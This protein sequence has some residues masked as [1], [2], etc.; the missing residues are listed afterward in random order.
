MRNY[1][2]ISYC[3]MNSHFQNGIAKRAIR[4]LQDQAQKQLVH[5]KSQWPKAIHLVFWPYALQN[6]VHLRNTLPTQ[7]ENRSRLENFSSINVGARLVNNQTF[8][9]PVYAMQ[10]ALQ[11]GS[12]IPKWNPCCGIGVNLVLPCFMHATCTWS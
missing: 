3:S 11:G 9:C 7:D 10:N 2:H 4:D 1:Q 6:A 12:T 5:A 8:G